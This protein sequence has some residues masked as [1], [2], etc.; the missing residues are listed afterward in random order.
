MLNVAEFPEAKQNIKMLFDIWEKLDGNAESF[1]PIRNMKRGETTKA[2]VSKWIDRFTK[3][4]KPM[5]ECTWTELDTGRSATVYQWRDKDYKQYKNL[6]VGDVALINSQE[7]G[8]F[9]NVSIVKDLAINLDVPRKPRGLSRGGK[10]R[11]LL[12]YDIEVFK[13]DI[14][15][16]VRDYFTKEWFEFEKG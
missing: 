10:H 6:E 13:H 8:G 2:V 7:N 4:G 16:E 15:I 12:V 1:E 5:I 3:T 11:S 9:F 14:L